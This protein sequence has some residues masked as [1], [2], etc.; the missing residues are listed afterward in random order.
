MI[1][2]TLPP[3][4]LA[5]TR[6]RASAL[7]R[8]E[9]WGLADQGLVSAVNFFTL[10]LLGRR[11]DPPDF[12][13]FVLAFTVLQSAGMLQAALLTRPHNVLGAVRRGR[14]YTDYSTTTA[15]AQSGFAVALAAAAALAGAV[16]AGAGVS[17]WPLVLALAPALVAWQLQEL[18]RRMLYTEGRLRAALA[19]DL[20]AYGS[21]AAALVV[22]VLL[23]RLS[24]TSAVHA[25]AATF[26]VGAVA[27]WWQLR[28]SLGGRFDRESLRAGWRFGKW[29]GAAEVGQW[30]STHFYVY[31]AGA[32]VSAAAS[33][34]LKAS[35]TLLGPMS[36]FLAFVTAYLPVKLA[37]GRGPA[38]ELGGRV[39]AG[40]L[41]TLLVVVPYCVLAAAFARPLLELVYGAAYAGYAD[42]VRLFALYYVLLAAST[43][44]VAALSAR[45]LTRA[46][47]VGHAGGGA[48]S[49][50]A[51]WAL[52]EA[53]GPEGAVVG[54][55]ASW[56][57]AMAVFW[58][59][60]R[61]DGRRPAQATQA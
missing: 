29:L 60:H 18:G 12:G 19:V 50:A 34:A 59:A 21:Q 54:M 9:I 14:D 61:S 4:P 23:G 5:G 37:R 10:I 20:L 33:G 43:V 11:L 51:G 31:L 36:V 52:L 7:L 38:G 49:L 28:R 48:V 16:A 45:E 25:L 57:A 58:P 47:F 55:I 41:A 26:A 46:V 1:E 2:P 6:A 53:L 15:V 44:V 22:L 56:L 39:R 27:A 13:A 32:L 17:A 8:I 24:P 42:V 40:Y 30:L 35:Q 3:R